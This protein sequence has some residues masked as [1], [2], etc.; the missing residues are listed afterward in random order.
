MP[1]QPTAQLAVTW[2]ITDTA[3]DQIVNVLNF[4]KLGASDPWSAEELSDL[5]DAVGAVWT[6]T[7]GAALSNDC[8]AITIRANSVVAGGGFVA[9]KSPFEGTWD[10]SGSGSSARPWEALLLQYASTAPGR[11]GRGRTFLPGGLFAQLGDN[12]DWQPT[13]RNTV[14]GGMLGFIEG[15][16]EITDAPPVVMVV[17]SRTNDSVA[18]ITGISVRPL[19]GI[20]R[21][22]RAGSQ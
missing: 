14:L 8:K 10:N 19:L 13:Y 4:A 16:Q 17:Y 21:D 20:Q 3:S 22:R 5:I 11:S 1:A 7:I 18:T 9:E 15:V 2:A 12:G 6:S